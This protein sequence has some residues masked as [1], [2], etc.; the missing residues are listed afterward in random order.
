MVFMWTR[1]QATPFILTGILYGALETAAT[2][3]LCG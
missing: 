1:H 2:N 3:L